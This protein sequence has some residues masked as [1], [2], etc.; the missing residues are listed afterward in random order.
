[1]KLSCR[2]LRAVFCVMLLNGLLGPS[3]ANGGQNAGPVASLTFQ[4]LL[5]EFNSNAALIDKYKNKVIEV[6]AEVWRVSPSNLANY[7]HTVF[8]KDPAPNRNLGMSL[9]CL[10]PFDKRAQLAPLRAG[11]LAKATG[12]F[13][14]R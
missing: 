8:L 5:A 3:I 6:T 14:N 10:I 13:S 9:Q 1:M 11:I 12:V 4:E 7:P 2:C